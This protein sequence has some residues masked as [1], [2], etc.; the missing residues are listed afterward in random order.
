MKS[1]KHSIFFKIGMIAIIILLLLIPTIMVQNLVHEREFTA[2]T[3]ITEVSMKWANGQTITGPYISIPYD[4][5]YKTEATK[6]TPEKITKVKE[7]IYLLPNELNIEGDISPEKR[8]R[9]IYEV[10]VYDS[11]LKING[12]FKPLNLEKLNILKENIHFDKASLNIG[13]E[14]LKGIEEQINLEW[15]N[16]RFLFD[17]GT[18]TNSIVQ[19]GIN[20]LVPLS[21]DDPN[22]YEFSLSLDLKGSQNLYFTPIGKTTNVHMVSSWPTP[23][24]TGNFIPDKREVDETGFNANWNIL[25]L[26]RNYPQLWAGNK[27]KVDPSSFGIDLLLPVDKYKKSYRVVRYAILFLVLTFLVFFFVEVMNRIFIHPIQYLLV[28]IALIIFYSLLLS[29][30]EH[31]EFDIAYILSSSLT[32]FLITGYTLAITKSRQIAIL[33]LGILFIMYGFIF[34]IIQLEDYALLIGSLGIFCILGITMYFSRKID[35]YKV[36]IGES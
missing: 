20:V 36:S 33:L 28:G 14:D 9:G 16:E 22:A 27:F 3:A 15:N 24:F 23:K 12:L 2:Q 29:I 13:I 34:T 11:K 5:I 18:S 19:N 31:L 21:K 4:I 8:Y 10:V 6:D 26:N 1:L 7:W 30:S 35:W 32:L 17:S 25:H